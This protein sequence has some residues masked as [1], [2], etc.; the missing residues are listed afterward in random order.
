MIYVI[1]VACIFSQITDISPNETYAIEIVT[2]KKDS[3]SILAKNQPVTLTV[4]GPTYLRIYTRIPWHDRSAKHEMYKVILQENEI[5]EKII[6]LESER[7]E[8]SK[9]KNGVPMSKWRSFYIEVPDGQNSYR[10]IHWSSPRD[11]ILLK[12]AYE[13]PKKWKD[14]AATEYL[15]VMEAIEEERFVTYYE[16]PHDRSVTL[17]IEGPTKLKVISRLN[18][19]AQTVGEQNY[20]LIV[21]DNGEIEKFPIK[22]YKSEI[23][24]Y[25]DR[26]DIVPSAAKR[27][28]INVA[29]GLH[30]L[31]FRLSGTI[32]K[33]ISLRFQVEE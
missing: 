18:Y 1:A 27:S 10:L 3:Y 15:S 33:S 16:L 24:T 17:R 22:C 8:V 5:D 30:T 20:T 4:E 19:D 29:D 32:A 7:S 26:K 11:T 9:G 13:S 28:Y 21:E 12:F 2:K 14:I 23:I 25:A 6:T 31:H